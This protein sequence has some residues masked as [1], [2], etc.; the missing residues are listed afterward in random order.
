MHQPAPGVTL[1][2]SPLGHEITASPPVVLPPGVDPVARDDR[3]PLS[4]DNWPDACG[5]L[6]RPCLHDQRAANNSRGRGDGRGHHDEASTQHGEHSDADR[7][8]YDNDEPPF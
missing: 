7:P 3:I 5:C 8:L 1:W 2:T 4:V 6:Y